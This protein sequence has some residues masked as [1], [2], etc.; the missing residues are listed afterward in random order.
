MT[1]D[2]WIRDYSLNYRS[3]SADP[4]NRKKKADPLCGLMDFSKIFGLGFFFKGT[5]EVMKDV[6]K[7]LPFLETGELTDPLDEDHR[8][9]RGVNKKK[10][11]E[12][13]VA[14]YRI[15]ERHNDPKDKIIM[16]SIK[17]ELREEAG[18]TPRDEF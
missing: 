4:V 11:L 2:N 3:R 10:Y 7:S 1:D 17:A 9:M 16:D 5:R 15:L 14:Q 18:V 8:D 13:R 12:N 6:N